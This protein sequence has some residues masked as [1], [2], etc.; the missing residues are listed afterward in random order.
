MNTIAKEIST[1]PMPI[2]E[3]IIFILFIDYNTYIL[4]N[5]HLFY[6]S[7]GVEKWKLE[8]SREN[9]KKRRKESEHLLSV[10]IVL[11][12]YTPRI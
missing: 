6:T 10:K 3:E 1:S 7:F 12:A 4:L 2:S 5:V 9:G 11:S 8:R